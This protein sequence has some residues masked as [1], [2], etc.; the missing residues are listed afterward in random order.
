MNHDIKKV[1][2]KLIFFSLVLF[3]VDA[4]S[5]AVLKK[6]FFS[7]VA[8]PDYR[9]NYVMNECN[10]DV[11]I[12]GSSRASHHYIPDIIG[13]ALH[14]RVYNAGRDAQSILYHYALLKS[15]IQRHLPQKIILDLNFKE[16]AVREQD[17]AKLIY[18]LPYYHDFKAVKEIVNLRSR[19]EKLKFLFKSYPYN[20]TPLSAIAFSINIDHPMIRAKI[21]DA[22]GYIP[23][24]GQLSDN[25]KPKTTAHT[26]FEL[27]TVKLNYLKTFIKTCVENNIDLTICISPSYHLTQLDTATRNILHQAGVK[28]LSFSNLDSIS[29][30]P[31]YFRDASHLNHKGAVKFTK[32][33]AET[34]IH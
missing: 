27:D 4:V 20:S 13:K 34:M 22:D 30:V 32:Y 26:A 33:F 7:Q 15:M 6:L 23:L 1:L 16:L 2:L 14:M 31:E 11:I 24:Y 17:Y 12:F 29:G 18:L 5:G 21:S 28:L 8:G 25:S 10:A 19:F 3:L 9:T